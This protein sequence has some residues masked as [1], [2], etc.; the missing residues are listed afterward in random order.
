MKT[1]LILSGGMDSATLAYEP[2]LG[3][4]LCLSFDYGQRHVRELQAAAAIAK[5]RGAEHRIIRLEGFAEACPGSSLTDRSV[6]VPHGHY[7]APTMKQTVVPSRN[8]IM[9]SA[10]F[11]I[12]VAHGADQIA[13]AVHSGDH[14]IYPDCRPE[15]IAHLTGALNLGVWSDGVVI[16]APYIGMSKTGIARRGAELGVPYALTYTCYE[17]GE[18]HCGLCGACQERKE[19]FRDAG[20]ADPTE[21][22]A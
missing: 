6:A 14:A 18:K 15:F 13:T 4:L 7:E 3:E 11:G 2:D 16:A 5:E 17:G 1:V 19:A 12:A 22:A 8:A 9:L 21:Y 20:V 10:A